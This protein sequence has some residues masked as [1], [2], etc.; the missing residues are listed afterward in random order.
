MRLVSGYNSASVAALM[1]LAALGLASTANASTITLSTISSDETPASQLDATFDFVISGPTELT[2][3]ATNDTGGDASFNINE[4]WFNA[5]SNVTSLTFDSATHSVGSTDVTT[6]WAPLE[7]A[8]NVDG[9]GTFDFGLD[10]GTGGSQDDLIGPGEFIDFV[11]T[12][13]G[14]GPFNMDDFVSQNGSGNIGAAKFVNCVGND[15]IESDDS[16]FGAVPEPGT[17]AMM[18]LGLMGLALHGR[19][20]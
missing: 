15:C 14:T 11:F 4:I 16:A 6:E 3:T 18:A 5:A 8:Q 2:L 1:A 9:F 12:I 13:S 19:R 10:N 17:A 7:T 20:R